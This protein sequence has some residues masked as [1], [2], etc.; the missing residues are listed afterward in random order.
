MEYE[1]IE[2]TLYLKLPEMDEV[3]LSKRFT[4]LHLQ[5]PTSSSRLL[6]FVEVWYQSWNKIT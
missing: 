2:K 4:G 1:G 5:F 3:F 6:L